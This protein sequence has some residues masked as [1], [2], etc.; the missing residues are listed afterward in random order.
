M[1]M[2][3]PPTTTM[4]F[5]A[6]L[7]TIWAISMTAGQP[8]VFEV[9]ATMSGAISATSA[10][11]SSGYWL[12]TCRSMIWQGYPCCRIHAASPPSARL[13]KMPSFSAAFFES[14]CWSAA[15][16]YLMN[17]TLVFL[18]AMRVLS[19]RGLDGGWVPRC[20]AFRGGRLPP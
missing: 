1:L 7:R 12:R 19:G 18:V 13:G 11:A 6:A 16:W 4:A 3:G 2:C 17:R 5:G 15:S 8:R 10:V 9:R 14:G 20:T